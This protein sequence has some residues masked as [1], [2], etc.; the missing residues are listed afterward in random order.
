MST[1]VNI[2][3]ETLGQ[4]SCVWLDLTRNQAISS[5]V[6]ADK[7]GPHPNQVFLCL[8]VARAEVVV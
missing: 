1:F 8:N 3:W 4:F 6:V 5:R 2:T 7:E